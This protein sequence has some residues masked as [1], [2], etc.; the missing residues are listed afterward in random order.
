MLF[1]NVKEQV[2]ESAIELEKVL[3]NKKELLYEKKC[4]CRGKVLLVGKKCF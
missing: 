4:N 2:N 1:L 3:L